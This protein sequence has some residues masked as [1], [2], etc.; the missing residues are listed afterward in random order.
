M[1]PRSSTGVSNETTTHTNSLST[2]NHQNLTMSNPTNHQPPTT[3]THSL[4]N[5]LHQPHNFLPTPTPNPYQTDLYKQ[6]P[7]AN[8]YVQ[9]PHW[10]SKFHLI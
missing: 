10:Q 3:S 5:G 2:I 8:P 9:S 6:M 4:N 1:P 7:P